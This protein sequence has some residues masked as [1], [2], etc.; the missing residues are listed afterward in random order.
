[1]SF[2]EIRTYK[3]LF[4]LEETCLVETSVSLLPDRG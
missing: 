2:T 3:R 1:M 4:P